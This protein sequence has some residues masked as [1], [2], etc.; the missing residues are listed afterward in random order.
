[1][2]HAHTSRQSTSRK[3]IQIFHFTGVPFS[4]RVG[5]RQNSNK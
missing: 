4:P 2:Q 1:M 5:S 3:E